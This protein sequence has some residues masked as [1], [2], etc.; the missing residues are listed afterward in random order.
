[1]WDFSPL[2]TRQQ[3]IA[4]IDSEIHV[5]T[6]ITDANGH[7]HKARVSGYD[8]ENGKFIRTVRNETIRDNLEELP[9][10]LPTGLQSFDRPDAL[11]KIL[12]HHPVIR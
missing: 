7:R 1:M 2:A 6:S 9:L 12:F 8:T 4:F 5:F 11:L 10:V 3:V